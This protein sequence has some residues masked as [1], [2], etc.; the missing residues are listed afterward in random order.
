[1]NVICVG[2]EPAALYLGILLKRRDRTHVV[3]FIETESDDPSPSST[4]VCNPLKRRLNLAD[5][6]VAAAANAEVAT[7]DRVEVSTDER[8]FETKG[9]PYA[10]VR[11]AG[12]IDAL[13]RIANNAGCEFLACAPDAIAAELAGADLVVIADLAASRSIPNA[14]PSEAIRG[15]TRF[16]VLESEK[17]RD[18]L[19]YLFR[20]TPPGAMHVIAWPRVGGSTVVVEAP[21]ATIEAN[22]DC[23]D[24]YDV[25]AFYRKRFGDAFKGVSLPPKNHAWQPFLTVRSPRWYAG[26]AVLM[27]R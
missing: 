12:L 24:V 20:S 2:A 5:A 27:G 8:Q 3:R 9:L 14:P 15:G 13:K 10:T 4:I 22:G 25:L 19:S 23:E 18:A 7:F 6:E 16:V 17:L 21:A 1:M 11:V 26:K